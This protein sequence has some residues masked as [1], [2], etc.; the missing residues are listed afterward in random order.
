M[1][2]QLFQF[3][4]AILFMA[5]FA[6]VWIVVLWKI[7]KRGKIYSFLFTASLIIG[8]AAVVFSIIASM[9]C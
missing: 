5:V 3:P 2:F 9:L 1:Q 4:T 8:V 6:L 7:R